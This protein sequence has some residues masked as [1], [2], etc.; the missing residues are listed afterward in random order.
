MFA[1]GLD[2]TMMGLDVTHKAL[3]GPAV[4][5]RLR[6]A[7]R[8]LV[9]RRPQRLLH[10][11]PPRD[12]RLGG[13]PIHDAVA[14]ARHPSRARDASPNVEVELESDLPRADRRRPVATDRA[15]MNVHVGVDIDADGFFD[16]LVERIASLG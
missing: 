8:R 5:E 3:L 13:A 6:A 2:V 1:S 9:R 11:L 16:L 4:E 7:G 10:P 15:P 12:L 14:V